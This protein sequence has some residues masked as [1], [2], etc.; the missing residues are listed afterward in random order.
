MDNY[1]Q[2]GRFKF[3]CLGLFAALAIMLLAG[4][5]EI[6]PNNFGPPNYGRYQISSWSSSFG[7]KGGGF[8]VFIADTATGETKLVYSR[9]FGDIGNGGVKKDELGR[10]FSRI[11]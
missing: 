5:S 2:K 11:R 8:G 9:V 3:F 7:D 4:A 10:T 1:P 6:G